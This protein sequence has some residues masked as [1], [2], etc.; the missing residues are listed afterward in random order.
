MKVYCD[1][2]LTKSLTHIYEICYLY[3]SF[4]NVYEVL[5]LVKQY[6]TI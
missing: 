2:Y 4:K 5:A 3:E 6:G 1:R